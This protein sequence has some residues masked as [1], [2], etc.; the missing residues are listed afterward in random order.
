MTKLPR[1]GVVALALCAGVAATLSSV[2]FAATTLVSFTIDD[3]FP[4]PGP[5]PGVF[6]DGTTAYADYRIGPLPLNW[7]VEAE[8]AP[9]GNLFILLNRKLDG[10]AGVLRCGENPDED[11]NPGIPRNFVL[12]IANDDA[13]DL[14]ADPAAG[15][16]LEDAGGTAWNPGS[17]GLPCVLPRND[18]PR[19]R[20]GT[21]Y[22]SR[23]KA[24]NVDFCTVTFDAPVSYEIRSDGAATIVPDP[25]DPTRK[26]LSY[27]STF[28]LVRFEPGVKAKTVGPAFTMPVRMEFKTQ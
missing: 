16:P 21:L 17:S 18:N 19:I 20:L 1:N 26:A 11:G 7:C 10:P 24:T 5:G 2:T 22:K 23:A 12:R 9:P 27:T 13:C 3:A 25:L 8:P 28:H 15:L 4:A 14:L 6:S